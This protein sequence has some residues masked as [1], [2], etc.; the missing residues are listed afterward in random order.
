MKGPKEVQVV[1]VTLEIPK[2]SQIN[3]G[4]EVCLEDLIGERLDG[5]IALGNFPIGT[6]IEVEKINVEE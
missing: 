5:L 4:R 2:G 6:S 3:F 1:K